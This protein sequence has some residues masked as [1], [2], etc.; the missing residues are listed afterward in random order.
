MK[1]IIVLVTLAV[2]L[3]S[4]KN[5]KNDSQQQISPT[6][7]PTEVV[8][9][10]GVDWLLGDWKRTND[11]EGNETFES[12]KKINET[13]YEGIGFTLA[14]GDTL[15]KEYMRLEHGNGQWSLFVKTADD[16]DETVF[17]VAELTKDSFVCVNEANDFPTHIAYKREGEKLKAK[18][19]NTEMQIDFEFVKK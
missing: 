13:K 1:K 4:C 12:W 19:S 16:K 15:S 3:T 17:K 5:E 11:K 14:K 10:A 9:K 7:T 18:I 2:T 6:E 8:Q